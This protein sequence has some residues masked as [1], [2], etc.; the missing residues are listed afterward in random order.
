M[1]D[2]IFA[3]ASCQPTDWVTRLKNGKEVPFAKDKLIV[4]FGDSVDRG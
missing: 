2:P 3:P 1:W 4:I